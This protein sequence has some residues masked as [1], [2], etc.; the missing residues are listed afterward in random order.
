MC[1]LGSGWDPSRRLYGLLSPDFGGRGF[2]YGGGGVEMEGEKLNL[3]KIQDCGHAYVAV[4][5]IVCS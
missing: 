1:D 2:E 4:S 3:Q 5:N